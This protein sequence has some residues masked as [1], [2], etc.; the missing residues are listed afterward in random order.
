M[1]GVSIVR[2]DTGFSKS[3]VSTPTCKVELMGEESKVGE[4]ERIIL[5]EQE[6]LDPAGRRLERGR[7]V[8][9]D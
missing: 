2:S 6:R 9:H 3:Y 8:L 1:H 4:V 5:A 7:L